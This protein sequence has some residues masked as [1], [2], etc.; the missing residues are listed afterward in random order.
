MLT[1]RSSLRST[2]VATVV[3]ALAL[4]ATPLLAGSSNGTLSVSV[5]VVRSC[6]LGATSL[7]EK[8]AALDLRCTNGAASALRSGSSTALS[9]ERGTLR[10]VVSTTPYAGASEQRDLQVAT[11]NF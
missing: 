4:M 5:T 2:S 6:A 9:T 3:G 11:L 1:R 10:L 8:S 7:G